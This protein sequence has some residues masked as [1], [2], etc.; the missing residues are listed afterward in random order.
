[1]GQMIVRNLDDDVTEGLRRR[2]KENG[3][4]VEAEVR[5]ILRVAASD[6]GAVTATEFADR[7]RRLRES[8]G[9]LGTDS[10]EL[11]REGRDGRP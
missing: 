10:V 7:A 11:I 1:M 2:A 4:S 8:L 6:T 3:R 9:P 5:E